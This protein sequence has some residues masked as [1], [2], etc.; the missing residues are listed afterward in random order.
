MCR[1]IIKSTDTTALHTRRRK[2]CCTGKHGQTIF[3]FTVTH[4][5]FHVFRT[6]A[7]SARPNEN[8][9]A[10]GLQ[11]STWFI[12]F[13]CRVAFSSDCPPDKNCSAVRNF[14]SEKTIHAK[15]HCKELSRLRL[16]HAT[17]FN[18][19]ATAIKLQSLAIISSGQCNV[20]HV[21]Y[22]DAWHGHGDG[23]LQRNHSSA[24]DVLG[25]IRGGA[26]VARAHHVRLQQRALQI[27]VVIDEGLDVALVQH[28]MS[29]EATAP[30]QQYYEGNRT[31]AAATQKLKL[32]RTLYVVERTRWSACVPFTMTIHRACG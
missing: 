25:R 19:I 4:T 20:R 3:H 13:K 18:D 27:H 8:V 24:T 11:P 17:T 14:T 5:P 28:R 16:S 26:A 10:Q 31:K 23:P 9:S 6:V 29:H 22:G 32:S 12:A 21:T 7:C 2:Q 1:G 30:T 15:Q